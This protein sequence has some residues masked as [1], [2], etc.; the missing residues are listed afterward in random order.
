MRYFGGAGNNTGGIAGGGVA[1][2]AITAAAAAAAPP[3]SST[4]TPVLLG[5][6]AATPGGGLRSAPRFSHLAAGLGAGSSSAA[7]RSVAGSVGGGCYPVPD[8]LAPPA[9][10]PTPDVRQRLAFDAAAAAPTHTAAT[11]LQHQQLQQQQQAAPALAPVSPAPFA[12]AMLQMVPE[13]LLGAAAAVGS[14]AA[15]G[16]GQPLPPAARRTRP[17][18][19]PSL[20]ATAIALASAN[21]E[22]Q[23]SATLLRGVADAQQRLTQREQSSK[24]RQDNVLRQQCSHHTIPRPTHLSNTPTHPPTSSNTP[25][26]ARWLSS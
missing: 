11:S 22:E 25:G 16:G 17:A 24:V 7:V 2:T 1:T 19:A 14:Q 26:N 6:A 3:F 5:W 18:P 12:S 10:A 15:P 9:A 23:R 20:P 8:G 13:L 4:G 21:A